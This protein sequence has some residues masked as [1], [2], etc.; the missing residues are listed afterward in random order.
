MGKKNTRGASKLV[1]FLSILLT[2][3]SIPAFAQEKFINARIIIDLDEAS[4]EG[5]YITNSRTKITAITDL[6][7]S[8]S[9]RAQVGDSLLIRSTFYEARRF[10]LSKNLLDKE[11]ISI[12]L[13]L[14]PIIL[15]EAIITQKLTGYLE[16]DVKYS[17]KTDAIEK[18][19]DELGVNPDASKL[20]D[21][22]NFTMWKDVTPFSLNVEKLYEAFSG[23]LRR[24]KNLY[25]YEG[26]EYII[27]NIHQYFGD[28]YF[29]NDL[30]IPKEKIRE[31]IFY[32]YST[33]LI[34][35]YYSNGNYLTIMTELSK[36]A[37]IYITRLNK[38]NVPLL[39]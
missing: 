24:R 38:W 26:R 33:S 11:L 29:I 3:I 14:Q 15:G 2:T 10:Y 39:D 17:S 36:I 7:G 5:I 35:S 28:D 21:S 32:A 27:E 19:Y 34:P 6:T 30:K 20:R 16:Q 4:A 13:N 9:M 8:F 23:D 12:H 31:F 18:L 25:Q 1:L 22:T 37:P